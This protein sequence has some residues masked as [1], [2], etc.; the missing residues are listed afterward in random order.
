M[1]SF[2]NKFMYMIFIRKEFQ[3]FFLKHKSRLN[4]FL[5]LMWKIQLS[6]I[7]SLQVIEFLNPSPVKFL[8][9]VETVESKI[10]GTEH[11]SLVSLLIFPI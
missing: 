10:F 1:I 4:I 6:L 7:S 2:L 5:K 3:Q 9:S 11:A 8:R